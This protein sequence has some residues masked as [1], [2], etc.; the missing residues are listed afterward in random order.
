MWPKHVLD[1][2]IARFS[3]THSHTCTHRLWV[4]L[5]LH[6][7]VS[8]SIYCP[9]LWLLPHWVLTLM[10]SIISESSCCYWTR[11][12]ATRALPHS[13][14]CTHTFIIQIRSSLKA[15]HEH[16][17]LSDGQHK[18]HIAPHKWHATPFCSCVRLTGSL[19]TSTR[20]WQI[21]L[22]LLSA[23]HLSD[24]IPDAEC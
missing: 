6:L 15:P 1:E 17:S 13:F 22:V 12:W 18:K 9:E 16:L 14:T 21:S 5:S 20:I 19:N 4:W 2:F 3:H 7:A 23:S 24:T 8:W 11:A 10:H